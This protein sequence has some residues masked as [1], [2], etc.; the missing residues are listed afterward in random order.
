VPG[1]AGCVDP[2]DHSPTTGGIVADEFS[3]AGAVTTHVVS[4][5]KAAGVSMKKLDDE[6]GVRYPRWG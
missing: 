3:R 4:A 5:P 1:I 2:V 6:A